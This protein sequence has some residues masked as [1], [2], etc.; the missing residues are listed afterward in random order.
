M[1]YPTRTPTFY[2]CRASSTGGNRVRIFDYNAFDA[3]AVRYTAT[4]LYPLSK[5]VAKT[6]GGKMKSTT[7]QVTHQ[8]I[9]ATS[10]IL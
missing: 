1:K 8:E 7:K 2:I 3:P 6:F 5:S 9:F 4:G 10:F